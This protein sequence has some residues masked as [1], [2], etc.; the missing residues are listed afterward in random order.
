MA[1]ANY[2]KK[3]SLA[4]SAGSR[5]AERRNDRSMQHRGQQQSDGERL[6]R[7][8]GS[9]DRGERENEGRGR[10]DV[11]AQRDRGKKDTHREGEETKERAGRETR[12]RD[13]ATDGKRG[14]K[15]GKGE[16]ESVE[17]RQTDKD[18]R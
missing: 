17:L 10:W 9:K 8:R 15:K 7:S 13:D 16:E 4:T 11:N 2:R 6:N 5:E 14:A 12:Y 1:L 3:S 18:G